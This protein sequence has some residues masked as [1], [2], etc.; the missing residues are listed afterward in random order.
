MKKTGKKIL[1]ID[2][3]PSVITLIK[4]H[5][6]K[7]HYK[8]E[9]AE[10]GEQG[11][12]L[13]DYY[14]PDLVFQ[15]VRLPGISGVKL[16]QQIKSINPHLPVILIT[17]Y[18]GVKLAVESIKKGAFDFLTKPINSEE[19]KISVRNALLTSNLQQEV[20]SLK[21][22]L[23]DRYDFSNVIGHSNSI[24]HIIKQ[25][26]IVAPTQLTVIL[27]GDSGTGKE[28]FANLIHQN[29]N[30]K[31][32][33]F[34]A[35]DCG[36]IP[37]T[38]VESELFGY[39]KGAFTGAVSRKEG[40]FEQA[41]GGTLFLD[42]ITNLPTPAQAKLLRV[43]QEK[44]VKRVGGIKSK[45]IDVRIIAATNLRLSDAVYAGHFREDLFHRLNEFS[46]NLP[47]VNERKDDIPLLAEYFIE[48]ANKELKKKV[49]GLSPNAIK[50]LLD[51]HFPGN[52][53]ELKNMMRRAVLMTESALIDVDNILFDTFES[54][55]KN[56]FQT[57]MEKGLSPKEIALKMK[58]QIESEM[59]KKV[60]KET[61]GN[62]TKAAKIL[63]ITRMTLYS[64]IKE[65][66][67]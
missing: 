11:L 14:L 50:K 6:E 19:L 38:L 55:E 62:K 5:L 51:Y 7:E 67:L 65:Y 31:Y 48:M 32:Y 37:D 26:K 34:V 43:I 49:I 57:D 9:S 47:T 4:Y 23:D 16:L 36:A 58:K 18:G 52:V 42:E 24:K 27:Q 41:N 22:R 59:I 35:V 28:L 33:P 20:K 46:I 15:D 60:L 13:I 64:K 12:K 45:E 53:R 29:S 44:K 63:K 39:E 61:A 17:A 30:R 21:S 56:D 3:D 1:I 2:D 54:R 25:V 40:E 10:T 8:I 66:D